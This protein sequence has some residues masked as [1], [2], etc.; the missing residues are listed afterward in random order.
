MRGNGQGFGRSANGGAFG[1]ALRRHRRNLGLSQADL[2]DATR[3]GVAARTIS[4]LERGLARRP[5][6]ETVRLLAV[7]LRLTGEELAEFKAAAIAAGRQAAADEAAAEL[8]VF[9]SA[10]LAEASRRVTARPL[11]IVADPARLAEVEPLLSAAPDCLLLVT[12][13]HLMSGMSGLGASV[14]SLHLVEG[15]VSAEEHLPAGA[16]RGGEL[17]NRDHAVILSRSV[18]NAAVF[19][20]P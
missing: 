6:A 18:A 8:A 5:H 14:V 20:C 11:I 7:A 3:G 13:G 19:R 9:A 15:V 4:D 10:R 1:A 17:A 12:S 16:V 2:A